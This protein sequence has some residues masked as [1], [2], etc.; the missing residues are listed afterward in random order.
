[1]SYK[2]ITNKTIYNGKIFNINKTKFKS[3]TKIFWRDNI[4]HPGAV[5]ILPLINKNNIILVNQFRSPTKKYLWEIPAGTLEKKESLINCAK[6]E[7]EEETGYKTKSIK[8]IMSFYPCP[9]YS[10]EIIHLYKATKLIKTQPNPDEDEE[11]K[12]KIFTRSEIIKLIAA[13]KIKDAKT[14]IGLMLWLKK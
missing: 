5:A 10:S 8:K 9:G 14:L 6:R 12:S 2:I 4:I 1:M 7:L 13:N 3:G 11:I